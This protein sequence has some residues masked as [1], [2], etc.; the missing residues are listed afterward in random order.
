MALRC[1]RPQLSRVSLFSL[2]C[3][4]H[5]SSSTVLAQPLTIDAEHT[6]QDTPTRPPRRPKVEEY[7]QYVAQNSA[8]TLDDLETFRPA[9]HSPAGSAS[10]EAEYQAL[11]EKLDRSFTVTQLRQFLRLYGIQV[12]SK[13]RKHTA[14]TSIIEKQWGWPSLAKSQRLARAKKERSSRVFPL[15]PQQAFLLLGKDGTEILSLSQTYN[16]RLQFSRK[17]LSLTISGMTASVEQLERH[18]E[19]LNKVEYLCSFGGI[20]SLNSRLQEIVWQD[21]QPPRELDLSASSQVLSRSSGCF[22]E[23]L[24]GGKVRI[25]YR[26]SSTDSLSLAKQLIMQHSIEDNE[27]PLAASPSRSQNDNAA[28]DASSATY[29]FYPFFCESSRGLGQKSHFRLRRV[30]KWF[31]EEDTLVSDISNAT[32]HEFI[33]TNGLG[34][35]VLKSQDSSVFSLAP[36]LEGQKKFSEVLDWV[37]KQRPSTEFVPG[38]PMRFWQVPN[39]HLPWRRRVVYETMSSSEEPAQILVCEYTPENPEGVAV[40]SEVDLYEAGPSLVPVLRGGPVARL[41]VLMPDDASDLRL[42]LINDL[43]L[44]E[45]S[46]PAELSDLIQKSALPFRS[47]AP[48]MFEHEKQQYILKEDFFFQSNSLLINPEDPSVHATSERRYKPQTSESYLSYES[49]TTHGTASGV[50]VNKLQAITPRHPMIGNATGLAITFEADRVYFSQLR[51]TFH[52]ETKTTYNLHNHE[53]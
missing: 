9:S 14:V 47:D 51:I 17:P 24:S 1:V 42:T 21:F 4:R 30:G 44:P 26:A 29:A 10:Y 12:S 3:K 33:A 40:E 6:T 18:V 11:L 37:H 52:S 50:N 8:L 38:A 32:I 46:W 20:Y 45:P 53:N 23:G 19:T 15:T 2:A 22:L 43:K 27:V 49:Q 25:W 31:G 41:D 7:L 48:L 13:M 35:V 16:V 34:H 36:P 5:A 28:N 39:S